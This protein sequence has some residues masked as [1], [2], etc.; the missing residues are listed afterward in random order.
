M[1]P[2]ASMAMIMQKGMRKAHPFLLHLHR[3]SNIRRAASSYK[4]NLL[5]KTRPQQATRARRRQRREVCTLPPTLIWRKD[6]DVNLSQRCSNRHL[7]RLT[8]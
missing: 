2:R 7:I 3:S 8:A 4:S 5:W 6:V 1:I